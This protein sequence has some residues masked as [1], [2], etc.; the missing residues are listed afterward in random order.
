MED[1]NVRNALQA[2]NAKNIA[3]STGGSRIGP[4]L[5]EGR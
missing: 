4:Q 5:D 2:S 3:P 1:G